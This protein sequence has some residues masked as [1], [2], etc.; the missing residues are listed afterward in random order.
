M[1]LG[2]SLHETDGTIIYINDA[3]KDLIKIDS[4]V[5]YINKQLDQCILGNIIPDKTDIKYIIDNISKLD[6]EIF[7]FE[8]NDETV[9]I[10]MN[11]IT[12]KNGEEHIIITYEN[13]SDTFNYSHLY[14]EI[15]SNIKSAIVILKPYKNDFV[16]KELN[17]YAYELDNLSYEDNLVGLRISTLNLPLINGKHIVEYVKEAFLNNTS[18]KMEN[19][20]CNY[21][22]NGVL[23]E[24]WRNV[25]F[26]AIKTGEVVVIYDD[27]TDIMN[28]KNKIE[29][30]DKQK[31]KFI[32]NMSHEIRG[33]INTIAGFSTLLSDLKPD[34]N[35]KKEEY[36]NIIKNS[37]EVLNNLIDDILDISKIEAGKLS[38]DKK[39]FDANKV[40]NQLYMSF[41]SRTN[42]K[43]KLI[44]QIE[45]NTLTIFNDEFR[46]KQILSNLLSN[47]IKFTKKGYIEMGY[48]IENEMVIFYV[49][50]TGVGIKETD[51]DKIFERFERLKEKT[52]N[53]YGL[54]LSISQE[55]SELM[56][57][58]LYFDSEYGKGSSFYFKIPI[59]LI[60]NSATEKNTSSNNSVSLKDK[61]ILLVE[62]VEFNAKLI[63]SYLEPTHVNIITAVD[64]NDALIKYNEN[65]DNIDLILMDIQ[66]PEIDGK[67]VTSIIRSIDKTTPIIAQTAYAMNNE[68][69]EILSHGF[70]DLIKKPIKK[71]L[72]IEMVAKYI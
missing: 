11:S 40:M 35:T 54:G 14:K 1:L 3:L 17:P 22:I 5:E 57:G 56:G 18:I 27:V 34:D 64:G 69:E 9:W 43:V 23:Y 66:I 55:L 16:I 12:I 29:D 53:G 60:K 37:S 72:L 48:K 46:L 50:D 41:K 25:Y 26:Y 24:Y 36:I 13:I 6:D 70:N 51:K 28:Y 7:K 4:S 32:S 8:L 68:I 19:V 42:N 31:S 67:E 62:D 71:E 45:L 63:I 52:K 2:A 33:P 20:N 47:S 65:R 21:T 58:E 59:G 38:I 39:S 10:K 49:K 61:T 15:F 30:S 44:K